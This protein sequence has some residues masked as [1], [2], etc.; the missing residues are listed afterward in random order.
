ME[1]FESNGI[2]MCDLRLINYFIS[3]ADFVNCPMVNVR[4]VSHETAA[5][6]V[7]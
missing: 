1:S 6:C 7:I 5:V 4:K 3:F 2:Y